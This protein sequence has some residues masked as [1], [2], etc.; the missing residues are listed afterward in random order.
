M[1]KLLTALLIITAQVSVAQISEVP[2]ADP[3]ILL[4]DG[5]YYAYGTH[6]NDGIEVYASRNLKYWEYQGMA[7][8]KK[9]TRQPHSFWAPEVYHFGDKYYMYYSGNK[10]LYVATSDKP[11]GPFVQA[12]E[13]MMESIV[14][15]TFTID[16]H[17]FIDD[18]G[19]IWMFFVRWPKEGICIWQVQLEE[20]YITPIPGTLKKCISTSADKWEN[21]A[22]SVNEG[23]N[24]V[25]HKGVYYLTYSAN[26]YTSQDYAVG[27]ATATSIDGEWTKYEGN[28]IVHRYK[29]L[30]GTGHH[31]LFRDKRGRLRIAFHAHQSTTHVHPRTMYIGTMKF[32]KDGALGMTD[33][34]FIRPKSNR[35]DIVK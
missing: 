3:F 15:D 31:T 4:D 25:K 5:V 26:G 28:P 27:Y 13:H 12:T 6:S 1:K 20:D 16:S 30:V 8:H 29:E 7:L 32:S 23:P 10:R 24:V 33:K 11:T 19:K 2:F 22:P 14:G 9:D 35:P 17:I 21:V 34:G 18:D